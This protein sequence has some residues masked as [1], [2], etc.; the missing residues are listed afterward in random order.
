MRGAQYVQQHY[1]EDIKLYKRASKIF[2]ERAQRM[3]CTKKG[4]NGAESGAS[5]SHR[6]HLRPP[7]GLNVRPVF[8]GTF[9]AGDSL[10]RPI[11]DL[12]RKG[13]LTDALLEFQFH[14][15][16]LRQCCGCGVSTASRQCDGLV[17]KLRQ[18]C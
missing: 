5:V 2:W 14:R 15:L 6:S 7:G 12:R 4:K 1:A 13:L 3:R 17:A 16:V 18:A 11:T 8:R 9:S 10:P